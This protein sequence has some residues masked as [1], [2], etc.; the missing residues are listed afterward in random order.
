MT[1]Y[2]GALIGAIIGGPFGAAIGFAIGWLIGS[3]INGNISIETGSFNGGQYNTRNYTTG[4][5]GRTTQGSPRTMF[6]NCLLEMTAYVIAADGKVMHS[7]METVRRFLRTN[8]DE[9][10]TTAC[11]ERLVSILKEQKSMPQQQ[12]R[13]RVMASC[14]MVALSL[15]A[16]QR[17]QLMAF[18]AE[19]AKADGKIDPTEINAMREVA[20]ALAI[21]VRVVDQLLSLGSGSLDDAYKVLGITPDAT[22]DEVRRAYR[23][24]ALQYHPDKVATLGKDVQETAK[25]KFQE[26]NEA[27]D[28]I[29][30]ERGL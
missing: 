30:K 2:I 29:Y 8:F 18:L 19:I 26:I 17:M 14:R 21:D 3:F 25:K 27:K 4:N 15:P 23:K 20:M 6:L 13:S 28:R 16:E 5:R 1:K 22:D 9:R 12:W 10:T 24:M 7:E 11:N